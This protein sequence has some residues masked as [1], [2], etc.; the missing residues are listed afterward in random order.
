MPVSNFQ[1]PAQALLLYTSLLLVPALA[2]VRSEVGSCASNSTAAEL[3][4]NQCLG[5]F[6]PKYL[7]SDALCSCPFTYVTTLLGVNKTF[8]PCPQAQA[9]I[10]LG[11]ALV[12]QC[13]TFEAKE[14]W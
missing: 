4:Y 6:A 1:R 14:K 10:T 9:K 8:A 13:S 11:H 12:A 5:K 7:L 2:V 3:A